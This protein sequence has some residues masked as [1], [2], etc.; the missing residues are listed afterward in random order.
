MKKDQTGA[1]QLVNEIEADGKFDFGK[2]TDGSY[3]VYITKT[4]DK[5][6]NNNTVNIIDI[7]EAC[8]F[9]IIDGQIILIN[10][11]TPTSVE[12]MV[13][14]NIVDYPNVEGEDQLT[15]S[16]ESSKDDTEAKYQEF[17]KTKPV[18]PSE[19]EKPDEDNKNPNTPPSGGN[20][21]NPSSGNE[22]NNNNDIQQEENN[23]ID[24]SKLPNTSDI[25]IDIYALIMSLSLVGIIFIIYKKNKE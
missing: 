14:K 21:E 16:F 20:N 6:F 15:A 1:Q 13:L 3:T 11:D 10:G 18:E 9:E 4:T 24:D 5:D 12:A 19:Q 25:A 8:Q 22:Q 2:L 23:N 17:I 7:L